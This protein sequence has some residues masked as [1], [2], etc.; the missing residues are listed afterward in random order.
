[1]PSAFAR[2]ATTS[3][4]DF[5]CPCIVGYGSSPSRRGPDNPRAPRS[6]TRSLRFQPVP[7]VRDGVFDHDGASAPCITAPHMLPSTVET[8]SASVMLIFSRLN[9]SPHTIAVYASWP[10]SP[11][12]SRNTRYRAG[13]TPYPDRTFTDWIR[14]VHLTHPHRIACSLQRLPTGAAILSDTAGAA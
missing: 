1:M 2:I 5:S 11:T 13:A 12:G 14:S 8:V 6:D 3:G 9:I 10:P 7:F 4:S